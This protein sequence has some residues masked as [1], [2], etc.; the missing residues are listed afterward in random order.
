MPEEMM[1]LVRFPGGGHSEM[2]LSEAVDADEPEGTATVTLSATLL[3][4]LINA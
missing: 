2:P 3:Q 1:V 4:E